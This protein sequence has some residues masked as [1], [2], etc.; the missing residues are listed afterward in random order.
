MY[1]IHRK[2]KF[3]L[4]FLIARSSLVASLALANLN[5]PL[6]E[7]AAALKT[8]KDTSKRC[9]VMNPTT[10]YCA[11]TVA[12]SKRQMLNECVGEGVPPSER[13]EWIDSLKVAIPKDVTPSKILSI[14]I[15]PKKFVKYNFQSSL[16]NGEIAKNE[17][18]I[19]EGVAPSSLKP[20]KY[21]YVI[22]A[23]GEESY[24]LIEDG[25]EYGVKHFNLARGRAV[26]IAGEMEVRSSGGPEDVKEKT[27]DYNILS[28]SFSKSI[29]ATLQKKLTAL[30]VKGSDAASQL[31][32]K[33]A[34]QFFSSLGTPAS[35]LEF[36]NEDMILKFPSLSLDK[37]IKDHC[38]DPG[39]L[40]SNTSL[41]KSFQGPSELEK[42]LIANQIK[43][44]L[45]HWVKEAGSK[46]I[47]KTLTNP[48][49]SLR[50]F[51]NG[52]VQMI[53][54]GEIVLGV[55]GLKIVKQSLFYENGQFKNRAV[56]IVG[57]GRSNEEGT[58]ALE[59]KACD[60]I[61]E[62]QN[63]VAVKPPHL[64]DCFSLRNENGS[65][66]IVSDPMEMDLQQYF[67]RE[68]NGIEKGDQIKLSLAV[69]QGLR[70]LHEMDLI[71]RD[72]KLAN[73]FLNIG[74]D[75]KI[76][77]IKVADFG[78]LIDLRK[79]GTL[80]KAPNLVG[81]FEVIA[82]EVLGKKWIG[83]TDEEKKR[84]A[85][86]IDVFSAAMMMQKMKV[87]FN[88]WVDDSPFFNC[89]REIYKKNN[90]DDI[91]SIDNPNIAVED[92]F[93]EFNECYH[94]QVQTF[95]DHLVKEA[96]EIKEKYVELQATLAPPTPGKRLSMA[97]AAK[98]EEVAIRL[99]DQ[100]YAEL[101][102]SM[103]DPDPAKRPTIA[104]VA[105]RLEALK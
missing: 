63:G 96:H 40:K 68:R 54:S 12:Q 88:Q 61:R 103:A 85:P 62:R 87:G 50:V 36:V 95:H 37:L 4:V 73:I 104:K 94:K 82:P 57:V 18:K 105:S 19:F 86:A 45:E 58:L 66:M 21:T 15:G 5:D 22:T 80:E 102:A 41:C 8:A 14:R 98:Q 6:V 39:F 48:P 55:G 43:E 89:K 59:A 75:N 51:S 92:H 35:Q 71:H 34:G 90:P 11:L 7:T 101:I 100:K 24:G 9:S 10:N 32:G 65:L 3:S 33:C 30:G 79:N 93:K 76:G 77:Q 69:A 60:E 42:E 38:G 64:L 99:R 25:L 31:L 78:E 81:T 44:N 13:R 52:S 29:Q 47:V 70:T 67:S 49:I 17:G 56:G 53:E 1:F 46:A 72:I 2:I 16:S 91:E 26:L 74:P 97:E 83:K 27:V 84:F 20:G 23:D 28:G